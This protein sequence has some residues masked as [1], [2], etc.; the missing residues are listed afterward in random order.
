MAAADGQEVLVIDGD[1]KVQKG[2]GQMLQSVGLVPTVMSD[3]DRAQAL[4]REKFFALALIDLDTPQPNA[5]LALVRWV[6][7]H[8]PTTAAIVMCSRKVFE[9]AIEAFRAGANDVVVKS[10]DQ[11]EYLKKRVVEACSHTHERAQDDKLIH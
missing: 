11:V 8:A 1:D 7:Q 9:A 4:M 6:K 3:P 10:P 2:L 5:G